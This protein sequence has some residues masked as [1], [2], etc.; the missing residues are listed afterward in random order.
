M[1]KPQTY[2]VTQ[3]VDA[4]HSS[5]G[6][7]APAAKRLGCTRQTINNYARIYPT[8]KLAIANAREDILDLAESK[9]F[10]AINSGE[11]WAIC[12]FLKTKG[13]VRGYV[14]RTES[15]ITTNGEAIKSSPIFQVVNIE[16]QD[17]M[18]RLNNGERAETNNDIPAERKSISQSTNQ[19]GA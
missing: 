12:F 9:L 6:L 13:K 5:A 10:T 16:T 7:M 19:A 15:D 11:A 17:L 14:E 1:P 8:V 18:T 3:V 4:L 2:S